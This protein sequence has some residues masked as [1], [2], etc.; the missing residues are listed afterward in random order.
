MEG[1]RLSIFVDDGHA[2]EEIE[3]V[4]KDLS[5]KTGT[6][7]SRAIDLILAS[8]EV[9]GHNLRS[10]FLLGEMRRK[11]DVLLKDLGAKAIAAI[12]TIE[13]KRNHS[14]TD[15]ELDQIEAFIQKEHRSIQFN[16]IQSRIKRYAELA[17]IQ[18][19]NSLLLVDSFDDVQ[20]S[21]DIY[22][23]IQQVK[24]INQMKK[25]TKEMSYTAT[26]NSVVWI[27]ALLAL[28][29]FAMSLADW[30]I[31]FGVIEWTAK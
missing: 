22:R 3:K 19:F 1:N 31:R 17:E 23:E 8:A 16:I 27:S 7:I 28:L 21:G 4:I 26:H 30:L 11:S 29:A 20:P 18:T 14:F 24:A 10:T 6:E 9:K 13:N 12:Y 15:E 25:E 2:L 5:Q